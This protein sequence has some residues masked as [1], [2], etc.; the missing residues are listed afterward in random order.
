MLIVKFIQLTYVLSKKVRLM[1][2]ALWLTLPV[3]GVAY[4]QQ[5]VDE[6]TLA[7][8]AAVISYPLMVMTH[9]QKLSHLGIELSFIRWKNPDQ[10]RAM[11]VGEQIDFTA[12]PSNLAA[13]FYNR[14]HQLR[15]L[16]IA[17]WN[18]MTIV[19]RETSVSKVSSFSDLIGKEVAL[20]FKNDM[21][22]I[23][24][25][26]L[27]QSQL[28]EKATFIKR[29]QSHNLSDAAQ[30]LLAGQVDHALLI[31]PLTSVVLFQSQQRGKEKFYRAINISEQWQKTFPQSPKL[32]QAGLVANTTVTTND[33]LIDQINMA[34][35]ASTKWCYSQLE[36]CADIVKTYLPKMPKTALI[37]AIKATELTPVDAKKAQQDLESFYRLLA[38][39][40][41]QRIGGKLPASKFYW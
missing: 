20:P 35:K 9:Q 2:T 13:T 5:V 10:L 4:A 29:R 30:L 36:Q 22:S 38:A 8:P 11:V 19:S 16:N 27:L 15:L 39:K 26:Q 1:V 7:G 25:N 40:N 12:M 6:V 28:G 18:I 34:Y 41:P 3:G 32:P 14:G 17:V 21:P 37:N 33:T 31:E 24:L 23:V